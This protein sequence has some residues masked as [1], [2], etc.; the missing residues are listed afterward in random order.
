[1]DIMDALVFAGYVF[2]TLLVVCAVAV[3]GAVLILAKCQADWDR[4]YEENEGLGDI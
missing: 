3:V 2:L 4:Y 1:M